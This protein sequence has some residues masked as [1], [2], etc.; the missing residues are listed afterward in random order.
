MSTK[1]RRAG[2]EI[3]TSRQAHRAA[4]PPAARA[5]GPAALAVAL[6]APVFGC[7]DGRG[8]PP[9]AEEMQ[10]SIE[11]LVG[12]GVRMP[13]TD[14]SVQ[15]AEYVHDGFVAAGLTDV[16]IEETD[17]VVWSANDW[18]LTVEGEEVPCYF[19]QHTFHQ[20]EPTSFSTGSGGLEAEIVYVGDG[21]AS[22]FAG[23]DVEGKIV[24]SD[25]R[26]HRFDIG[27]V[28]TFALD[29][30]DPE[31]TIDEDFEYIDPYS[32]RT[33]P[34]NYYNAMERG[35]VGFI[36]I[37][38]DY[39]DRHEYHNEGY[40]SYRE[41]G[42]M[43]IPGLWVSPSVG[44]A[45]AQ[46]IEETEDPVMANMVLEGQLETAVGRSVIGYV[47]GKTDE[48]VMVQSHHDSN[49][50]GAV[51]D[52]SGTALVMAL[53]KHYGSLPDGERE[54]TLLFTTMDTHFTDYASHFAFVERHVEQEDIL[55]NLTLEHIGREV[56][57]TADG[58][59]PTDNPVIKGLFVTT[60][61][62]GL[63]DV[64][65]DAFVEHDVARTIGLP[66]NNPVI[67][68]PTDASHFHGE[69]VPVVNLVGAPIYLYDSADTLDKVAV[70]QLEPVAG[71]SMQ[72]LDGLDTMP[73][74]DLEEW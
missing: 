16:A 25:V 73:R 29:I 17:T 54:R 53:A 28:E 41:G 4:R 57:E 49:T 69:G 50:A 63:S 6:S 38:T 47:R 58:L 72:I 60:E 70:D 61:V 23:L 12:F 3:R 42:A 68:L 27:L 71:A 26:F 8:H 32:R 11:T 9:D 30:H 44:A 22:D 21:A 45:L 39:L 48:I 5:V 74:E 15:A 56:E 2:Q 13:G 37:L 55:A 51:E 20:Q 36:G 64:A 52:A 31:G 46:R 18:G 14:A 67:G 34:F 40:S 33:F 19:M 24:L 35:A 66:A 7:G 43:E 1:H 62:P 59:V 65:L 10:Q